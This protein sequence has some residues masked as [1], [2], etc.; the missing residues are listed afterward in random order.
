LTEAETRLRG[1]AGLADSLQLTGAIIERFGIDLHP[2][3]EEPGDDS[4]AALAGLNGVGREGALIQPLRL[5]PLVSGSVWGENSLWTA[6]SAPD[7]VQAAMAQAGPGAME[8]VFSDVRRAQAAL[9]ALDAQLTDAL[10]AD[11]PPS[12]QLREVLA[13]TERCIRR[14]APLPE[15]PPAPDAAPDA[16]SPAG[17]APQ[18][19]I[20]SR[21]EAFA[22]LLRISAYFRQAEPHSPLGFALETLVRRGRMDFM[23]LLREL[24]PDD[25][26]REAFMTKAGIDPPK[27]EEPRE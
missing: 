17:R 8:K 13:D 4:F 9:D 1:H 16:A 27:P 12:G 24:V 11:A 14:L 23:S 21:E 15:S 7:A 20:T 3:P 25:G 22:Q 18:G 26:A 19:P 10:G 6:I 2:R 5:V